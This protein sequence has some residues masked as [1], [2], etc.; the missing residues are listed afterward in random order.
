MILEGMR[1]GQLQLLNEG[2]NKLFA[3]LSQHDVALDI[4]IVRLLFGGYTGQICQLLLDLKC[5][6]EAI[7]TWAR[8]QVRDM[9]IPVRSLSDL[10]NMFFISLEEAWK[11]RQSMKDPEIALIQQAL[12]FID[13]N[14]EEANL[15]K[16]SEHVYVSPSHL[17]RMF[18]K[19]LNKR[20]VDVIKE[21]R[22]ERAKKFLAMGYNVTE[23]AT[24]VG[25]GN[26]TY[27]S[28]L[29]KEMV[30][31]SPSEYKKSSLSKR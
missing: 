30:G 27:F 24:S 11:V 20:F 18:G 15:T 4:G 9:M 28:S 26:I 14:L 17:S 7:K 2:T 16:V 13:D 10:K 19:V 31:C 3:L 23:T 5:D 22:I 8:R 29:F 25:Y 6:Q 1:S 21:K 12:A